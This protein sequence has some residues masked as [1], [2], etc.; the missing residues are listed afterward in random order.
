LEAEIELVLTMNGQIKVLY[1]IITPN[2]ILLA[3]EAYKN[4]LFIG[5]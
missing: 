1:S 4:I 2:I 3:I 5:K